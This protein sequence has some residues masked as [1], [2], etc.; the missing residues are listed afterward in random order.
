M[1]VDAIL[2]AL[3]CTG[4]LIVMT[5]FFST[6]TIT[7][8]LGLREGLKSLPG[9]FLGGLAIGGIAL[10]PALVGSILGWLMV[11]STS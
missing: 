10:G 3:D 6:I 1:F 11:L 8:E 2:L 4:V 9:S 7:G 5:T